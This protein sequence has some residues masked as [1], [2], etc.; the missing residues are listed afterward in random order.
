[1]VPKSLWF[2]FGSSECVNVWSGEGCGAQL[3][4]ICVWFKRVCV[5][6]RVFKCGVCLSMC[7]CLS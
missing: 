6:E 1:V 3:L 7:I 2:E 5:C 4:A